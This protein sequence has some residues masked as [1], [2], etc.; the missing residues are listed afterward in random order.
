[1]IHIPEFLLSSRM[2]DSRALHRFPHCP[3][4]VMD[5]GSLTV[6]LPAAPLL[7]GNPAMGKLC[8]A[9]RKLGVPNYRGCRL[10]VPSQLNI[11]GWRRH[12]HLLEDECLVDMLAFGFPI[13]FEG[14]KKP[15]EG[16]PNH[17][18][19]TWHGQDITVFLKKDTELSAMLGPFKSQPFKSSDRRNPMM[20]QA[21]LIS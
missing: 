17:G 15:R 4:E 5:G 2:D 18:S 20:T 21:R 10:P 1:M 12:E 19:A 13:G 9:V 8:D 6:P 11:A 3:G 7:R 14:E 16:T